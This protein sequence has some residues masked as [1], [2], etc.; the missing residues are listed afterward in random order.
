VLGTGSIVRT[1]GGNGTSLGSTVVARFGATGNFLAPSFNSN[2][3][4]NS[5]I[6]YDS[7]WVRKALTTGGPVVLGV[8]EY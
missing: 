7:E 3:S 5:T 8:S 4:G 6:R 2:G 1:G